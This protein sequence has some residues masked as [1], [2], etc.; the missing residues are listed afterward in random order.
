MSASATQG[1]HNKLQGK[2]IT[3]CPI[4]YDGH[5]QRLQSN[6]TLYSLA[7]SSSVVCLLAAIKAVA[8]RTT[9]ITIT[10]A[11]RRRRRVR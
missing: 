5:K 6:Y 7:F 2:N 8:T 1:G 9:T 4:P 11:S 10:I 3:A